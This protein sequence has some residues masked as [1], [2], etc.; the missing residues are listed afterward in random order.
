MILI[1]INFFFSFF[2]SFLKYK[3]NKSKIKTL[4]KKRLSTS[5][6]P[7]GQT[8]LWN[9]NKNKQEAD[10]VNFYLLLYF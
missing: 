5:Q 3:I 9:P 8:D 10:K 2:L 4:K 7:Q 6:Q 1:I